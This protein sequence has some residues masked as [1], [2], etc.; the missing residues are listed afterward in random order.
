MANLFKSGI[1][2]SD[3]LMITIFLLD[4]LLLQMDFLEVMDG[5]VGVLEKIITSGI[6]L[7]AKQD[8]NDFHEVCKVLFFNNL[9]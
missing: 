7:F 2:D 4:R 1:T 9:K 8:L 6:C 3:N 5:L